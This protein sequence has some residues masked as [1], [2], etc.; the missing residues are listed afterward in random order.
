MQNIAITKPIRL[1]ELFAGIGSQA[2]ALR[3]LGVKYENYITCEWWVQPNASYKAIHKADDSTDY[4]NGMTKE[5]LQQWLFGKG[6]SSD[7]KKPMTLQQIQRKPEKWIRDTY[8]N[9]KATHNLVNIQQATGKELDIVD[10]EK[11]EY[12]LTYSFPCQDLSIAGKMEGMDEGSNTQSSMLWEVKRLLEE[13]GEL[14]QILLMENV[15]QVMR[16]KNIANF[17]KWRQFLESRGYKNYAQLLNAKDYGVAQNGNRAFMVSVLG[18]YN[19]TFPDPIP[20]KKCM[21]DYLEDEVAESYYV[22]T[23]KAASLIADMIE[24]EMAQTEATKA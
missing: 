2:M 12:I 13:C 17:E 18:D 5:Q 24:S 8:N 9:I 11:Y 6:I 7:G 22:N 20:L 23:E 4:S 14:P 3:N 21:E 16:K 19:Y 10:T 15:P 1:I